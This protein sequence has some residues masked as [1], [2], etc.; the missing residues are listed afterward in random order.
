[1]VELLLARGANIHDT[2][3]RDLTALLLGAMRGHKAVVELLLTRGANIQ[4][5]DNNGNTAVILA[6][7]LGHKDVVKVLKKW[8]PAAIPAQ[9]GQPAVHEVSQ[10]PVV[11]VGPSK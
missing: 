10:A 4:D 8:K 2:S 9:G 5:E 1:V 6:E 3:K 7:Q 11:K